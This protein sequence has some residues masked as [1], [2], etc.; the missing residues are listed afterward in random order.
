MTYIPTWVLRAIDEA[1]AAG[2]AGG[3]DMLWLP[4]SMFS[5]QSGAPTLTGSGGAGATQGWLLDAAAQEGVCTTM[6][7]PSTWATMHVDMWWLNNGAGAGDVRWRFDLVRHDSGSATLTTITNG[8]QT[9]TAAAQNV[10]TVSRMASNL[11]LVQGSQYR[12]HPIRVAADVADTLAND[13]LLIGIKMTRV[14]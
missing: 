7:P 11:P 1:R 12:V 5:A 13:V 6:V 14:S 4:G 8:S 2:S 9:L 3:T 10:F